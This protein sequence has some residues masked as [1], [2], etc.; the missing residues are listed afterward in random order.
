MRRIL[1]AAATITGLALVAPVDA[2]SG[3]PGP[4]PTGDETEG[5][6]QSTDDCGSGN[7]LV[8][9][10]PSL[11]WPPN[12]KYYG[13]AANEALYFLAVDEDGGPIDLVT[14]GTHNQYGEDGAELNGSGNTG[15]EDGDGIGDDVR[16]W[17]DG[18]AIDTTESTSTTP[19]YGESGDGT[20]QTNWAARSERAGTGVQ[21]GV[22]NRKYTLTGM[23]T[24]DDGSCSLS[25][26]I[27]VPHDMGVGD[28]NGKK[29]PVR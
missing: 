7:S 12:H 9:V 26:E 28:G 6:S 5:T 15:D 3:N 29:E 17:D 4:I 2:Q 13:D 18:G 22:P 14:T 21:A 8:A 19:V 20:V 1:L 11:L 10:H 24:F 23:A 16:P 25:I 27:L